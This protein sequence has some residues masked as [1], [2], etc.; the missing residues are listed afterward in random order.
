MLDRLKPQRSEALARLRTN[1]TGFF[2]VLIIASLLPLP[3]PWEAAMLVWQ[4]YHYRF[5]GREAVTLWWVLCFAG[6]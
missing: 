6:E 4:S 2:A 1:G 5:A 3:G